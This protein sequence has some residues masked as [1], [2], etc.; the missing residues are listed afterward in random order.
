MVEEY[1]GC[2]LGNGSSELKNTLNQRTD[3]G[4]AW[5]IEGDNCFYGG[6]ESFNSEMHFLR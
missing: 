2:S 6:K 3:K 5:Y 1:G 4:F